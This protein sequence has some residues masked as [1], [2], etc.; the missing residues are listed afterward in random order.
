MLQGCVAGAG[1]RGRRACC[2]DCVFVQEL[3]C[4]FEAIVDADREAFAMSWVVL[5]EVDF[6]DLAFHLADMTVGV[7]KAGPAV[8]VVQALIAAAQER[9]ARAHAIHHL[10]DVLNTKARA[11]VADLGDGAV[12]GALAGLGGFGIAQ[13][14]VGIAAFAAGAGGVETAI[15][16]GDL[17]GV[18]WN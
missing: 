3:G 14:L 7:T 1:G 10:A 17:P 18:W 9:V 13:A 2:R 5:V 16:H 12:L 4:I 6:F 11:R 15:G 8:S